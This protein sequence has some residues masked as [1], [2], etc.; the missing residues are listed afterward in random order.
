MAAQPHPSPTRYRPGSVV[1]ARRLTALDGEPIAVPATDGKLVHL[2]FRRFAGCPVCNLHLRS[3]AVRHGEIT[4][5][6]VRE[7]VVFHSPASELLPHADG[8]PFAL[9]ADGE[10]ALYREFGVGRG[11]RSVLDPR[12]WPAMAY[13]VL[14]DLGPVLLRRRRP[15]VARPAGGRLGLPADFLIAPDGTV[16]AATYGAHANDQWSVDELLAHAATARRAGT[17]DGA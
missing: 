1:A 7:V 10:Q 15:P 17:G 16:V 13:G 8:L 3:I 5:A 12:A 6:G 11:S 2:Q 9:I 14:R 4:A